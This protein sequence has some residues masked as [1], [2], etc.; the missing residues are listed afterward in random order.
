MGTAEHATD[1]ELEASPM[2]TGKSYQ[3][4]GMFRDVVGLIP[5]VPDAAAIWWGHR[6]NPSLRE[7]VMVAVARANACR[8]CTFV[9]QEWAVRTGASDAEIV[10]LEG[11][12]AEEFDRAAW[13][14]IAYARAL[15]EAELGPVDAAVEAAVDTYFTPS[16]R[17]DIRTVARFMTL[18]NRFSNTLDAFRARLA[19]TPIED[20]RVLDEV[21]V[22]T[23]FVL[24]APAIVPFFSLLFGRS[25]LSLARELRVF[26]TV[27]DVGD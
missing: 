17:R 9:H 8:Y 27:S 5:R 7:E 18:A 4:G 16:R 3:I 13:T 1:D 2:S 21:V 15:A 24:S 25:P 26:A 12:D 20:S 6:L 10:A 11:W 23:G 19:G 14:A 22:A